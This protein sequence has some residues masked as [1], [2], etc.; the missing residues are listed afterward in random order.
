MIDGNT[1]AGLGCVYAGA[2]VGAWYPITPSTS[3][4]DAFKGFCERY[5]VDPQTGERNFAVLQAEDELAAVGMVIGASWNGAR[6]FTPTS[7]PGI[8]LMNEFVGLG[9]LRR[10]ALRHFRRAARRTLHRHAD[11]HAA[12]GHHAVRLRLAWRYAACA[13]V[14]GESGGMLLHGRAGLR[15]RRAPADAGLRAVGSGHRHER[16]D[17]PGSASGTTPIKP[18][19]GKVLSSR[20]DSTAWRN[21]IATWIA[22]MMRFRYR[23][24][25]GISPKGAYFTRGSGHNQY[26]ALHRGFRRIPG[27]ARPAEAQ[28]RERRRSTCRSRC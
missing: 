20:G 8:S 14:P 5:R 6:A 4:M 16:L 19:R 21:S 10:S 18:D 28:V 11:A 3:L 15:S 12:V 7:G 2:T 24:L 27:G 22:T 17:V 25:P 23:T 9:V 1:A 13:A 26:G